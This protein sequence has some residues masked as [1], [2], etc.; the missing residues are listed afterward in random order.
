MYFDSLADFFAMGRH[1]LYVWLS[2]G[3]FLLVMMWNLLAPTLATRRA[4]QRARFYWQ[5][6]HNDDRAEETHETH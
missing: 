3:F 6:Q 5:R 2:Y 1:G 4:V